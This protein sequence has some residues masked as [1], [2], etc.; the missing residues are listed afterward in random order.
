M[1]ECRIWKED[2]II[3]FEAHPMQIKETIPLAPLTTFKIGG[4]AR[5]FAEPRTQDELREAFAFARENGVPTLVLGGGSNILVS[6]AGFP[7][8]V[9]HPQWGG[10]TAVEEGTETVIVEAGASEPW[11]GMVA[12]AVERGY[13]G[14]ENLSHIPGSCG[15]FPVQNVGAYGAEASDVV[16]AVEAYDTEVAAVTT[17]DKEQCDF[18]YRRSIF[19]SVRK[20]RY[21]ILSVR[22][23]LSKL[24]RPNVTYADLEKAF[25]GREVSGISLPEIREAVIRIRED[26][27][28]YPTVAKNGSAGSFFKAVM[29]SSEGFVALRRL[30]ESGCGGQY[31]ARLERYAGHTDAEGRVKVPTAFLIDAFGLKGMREGGAFLNPSQPVVILNDG[32][33]TASDVVGLFRAVRAAISQRCGLRVENEPELVGFPEEELAEGSTSSQAQYRDDDRRLT[34]GVGQVG[35]REGENV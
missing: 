24:P 30:V 33:A 14:I 23:K 29:V 5:F 31:A 32:S 9:V 11:D 2:P 35:E 27:F 26:K 15:A 20:G 17:L 22:M 3:L 13:W 34:G 16:V 7:G 25:A 1:K 19:N 8:L 10:I 28:P 21:V 6:D 18:S 4:P 12:W